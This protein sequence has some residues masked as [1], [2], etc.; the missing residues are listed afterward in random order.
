MLAHLI[1][2]LV[3]AQIPQTEPVDAPVYEDTAGGVALPR[4]WDDW[5]FE[6]ARSR[7]MTTVI[8]H[9]RN[10]S[11]SAQLYGSLVV[12]TLNRSIPLSR[13]V[14]ERVFQSWQPTLGSTFQLL[15]RDSLSVQ[16]LPA[17]HIVVSGA[18]ARA[19]LDVEEY[20]I[21]RGGDLIVLQFRYPRA[22][23]RD[24]IA[25]GYERALQGLRIRGAPGESA[26]VTSPA[27]RPAPAPVPPAPVP[28]PSVT[29]GPVAEMWALLR[30]SP[31]RV[32]RVEARLRLSDVGARPEVE[33]RLDLINDGLPPADQVPL[34]LP[35]AATLDSV[36]IANGRVFNGGD[37]APL[38]RVPLGDTIVFQDRASITVFYRGG[39]VAAMSP[40]A[41]DWLP[42][43]QAPY[44]SAGRS[45]PLSLPRVTLTFD[46]PAALGVVASGHLTA[47]L[48]SDARRRETWVAEGVTAAHAAFIVGDFTAAPRTAG[49]L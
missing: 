9:P 45:R 13:L 43:V 27:P 32:E 1:A 38:A 42:A 48:S 5:V 46:V 25:F 3:A 12:T 7:G 26:V 37:V 44:D 11:L 34:W 28:S 21:A 2:A 20:L 19:A 33:A 10:A 41:D 14:E 16:G 23:T 18:I 36:R 35:R 31:W 4:P 39:A 29:T 22:L 6:P 30:G 49:R 24:S 15:A 17:M 47:D 8:L 40:V